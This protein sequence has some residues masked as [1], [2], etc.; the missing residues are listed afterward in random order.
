MGKLFFKS[1]PKLVVELDENGNIIRTNIRKYN[2][3][4]KAT[5]KKENLLK[6]EKNGKE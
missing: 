5:N 3:S 1:S 4:S 2:N 6:T